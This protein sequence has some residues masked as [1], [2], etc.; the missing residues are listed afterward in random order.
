MVSEEIK[1]PGHFKLPC[2]DN[3]GQDVTQKCPHDA[4]SGSWCQT[5][6]NQHIA[7]V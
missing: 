4:A 7:A 2:E 3:E 5:V 1:D 6:G